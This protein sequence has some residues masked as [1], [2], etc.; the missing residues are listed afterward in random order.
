[1]VDRLYGVTLALVTELAVT[2]ARL[3]TLERLL[4]GRGVVGQAEIEQYRAD[5]AAQQKRSQLQ[6]DYLQRVLRA[7]D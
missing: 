2:R 6:D 4:E 5:E 3:D 7:L 1:M